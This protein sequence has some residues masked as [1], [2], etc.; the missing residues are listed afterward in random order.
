MGGRGRLSR[1]HLETN[2][3]TVA[4]G[5]VRHRP[6]CV[7]TQPS[8]AHGCR[9]SPSRRL[10]HAAIDQ[11]TTFTRGQA[12]G[13]VRADRPRPAS[14]SAA[15]AVNLPG[16]RVRS[17][18]SLLV[19]S[20]TPGERLVDTATNRIAAPCNQPLI[21]ARSRRQSDGARWAARW[22]R[23]CIRRRLRAV[24]PGGNVPARLGRIRPEVALMGS[25]EVGMPPVSEPTTSRV[26]LY[27]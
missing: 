9:F 12:Y 4:T 19:A 27:R 7:H 3:L 20:C 10:P 6:H 8:H 5:N 23:V 24:R 22:R 1:P 2:R 15:A 13:S 11:P 16:A 25:P 21:Q 26:P 17:P 14:S 18:R